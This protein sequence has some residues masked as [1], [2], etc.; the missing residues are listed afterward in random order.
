MSNEQNAAVSNEAKEQA[1]SP[2]EAAAMLTALT[3]KLCNLTSDYVETV[4]KMFQTYP[5]LRK[6]FDIVIAVDLFDHSVIRLVQSS[7]SMRDRFVA[8]LQSL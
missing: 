7:N 5:E 4:R 3:R 6:A 8:E 2:E 1:M